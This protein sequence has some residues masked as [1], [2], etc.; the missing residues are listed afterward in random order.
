[1]SGADDLDTASELSQLM[2]DSAVAR[3][4][5][6]A[7]PEQVRNPDGSWPHPECDDC[8]GEIIEG[9]L[10]IG[11]I[12]CIACQTALERRRAGL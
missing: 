3:I 12:R 7:K 10:M 11:K 5:K 1:M 6:L 2:N 8:G 9:R 4:Q